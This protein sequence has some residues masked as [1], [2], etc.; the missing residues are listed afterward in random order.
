MLKGKLLVTV[1]NPDFSKSFGS[2]CLSSYRS[3]GECLIG[4][5]GCDG[6]LYRLSKSSDYHVC[7]GQRRQEQEV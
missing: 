6:G 4:P 5:V 1:N 3:F 7:S 2:S